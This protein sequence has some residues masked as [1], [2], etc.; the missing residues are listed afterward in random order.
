MIVAEPGDEPS[1]SR[2]ANICGAV[3]L[4]LWGALLYANSLEGSFHF[5]DFP[6]IVDNPAIRIDSLSVDQLVRAARESPL[7]PRPVA[8]VTFAVNYFVHEY[9]VAGYHLVNVT[10]HLLTAL[11]FFLSTILLLRL[12]ALAPGYA[13]RRLVIAWWAALL[14]LSHPIQVQAV[15]YVVQ[16]MASLAAMFVVWALAALLWAYHR[17]GPVRPVA[18]ALSV[19][20]FVAGIGTKE[21]AMILPVV[22]VL[23]Y[24]LLKGKSLVP[25]RI[26]RFWLGAAA[27]GLVVMALAWGPHKLWR[28]FTIGLVDQPRYLLTLPRA[29]FYSLSLLVWPAPTRL[30]LEHDL[31]VSDSLFDPPS[32][33]LAWIGLFAVCL[34]PLV[35]L[36]RN[37]LLS[38]CLSWFLILFLAEAFVVKHNP[39]FEHRFYLPS[40]GLFVTLGVG[41]AKL[42]TGRLGRRAYAVAGA[43]VLVLSSITV[44]RNTVWRDDITL[45]IDSIRSAPHATRAY[46]SLLAALVREG[47]EAEVAEYYARISSLEPREWYDR[48]FM[49]HA[50]L[51]VGDHPSAI[52]H[53]GAA[54]AEVPQHCQSREKLAEAYAGAGRI[55]EALAELQVFERSCTKA[56]SL[57]L[58]LRLKQDAARLMQAAEASMRSRVARDPGDLEARMILSGLLINRGEC[59]EATEHLEAILDVDPQSAAAW[60]NLGFCAQ[61]LGR[62]EQ[63]VEYHRQAIAL[64]PRMPNAHYGLAQALMQTGRPEEAA[65]AF[66]RYLEIAPPQDA[67]RAAAELHLKQLEA[68]R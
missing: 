59:R 24:P 36:R 23:A 64:A 29:F 27:S 66:R 6:N 40:M 60:S 1:R 22:V 21:T 15:T 18:I 14:W 30:G 67:F 47:R 5:D 52:R 9:D 11:G 48:Y 58:D 13:G 28:F 50:A 34:L 61:D 41:V 26:L 68:R 19:L 35:L 53:L 65:S 3:A 55:G 49:G 39:I 2:T 63:A 25:A 10:A 54:L 62:P 45:G 16:R 57:R 44:Y 17:G 51:V 37:R 46:P 43:I 32:T 33:L 42:A 4:V 8:Y 20:L 12:P 31:V 7:R 38:V 56:S